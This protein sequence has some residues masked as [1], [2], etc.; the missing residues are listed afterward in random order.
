MPP[1]GASGAAP[2][3]P[4]VPLLLTSGPPAPVYNT[5]RHYCNNY[6]IRIVSR[7]P[8]SS[9]SMDIRMTN[10]SEPIRIQ[11]GRRIRALRSAM[12]WSQEHLGERANLHPTYVGGIERG[13]R[14]LSLDNLAKLSAAFQISLSELF[15]FPTPE[16]T[17]SGDALRFKVRKWVEQQDR[18]EEHTS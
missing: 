6:L 4:P 5:D 12:G 8:L 7:P 2:S 3:R 13:E 1:P 14:N 16:T 11:L 15:A 18:S 10:P 9:P 17:E